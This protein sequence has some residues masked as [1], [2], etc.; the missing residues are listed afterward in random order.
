MLLDPDRVFN[1]AKLHHALLV[2]VLL[3]TFM[4]GPAGLLVF[5]LLRPQQLMSGSVS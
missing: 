4:I 2:P 3:L 1:L 5:V